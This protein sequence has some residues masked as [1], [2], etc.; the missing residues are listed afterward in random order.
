MTAAVRV[1][2]T[3]A[4]RVVSGDSAGGGELIQHKDK[5]VEE[6]VLYTSTCLSAVAQ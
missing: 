1:R 6:H 5:T 4:V 2:V 3:A